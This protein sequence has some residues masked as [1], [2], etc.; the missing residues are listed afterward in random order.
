MTPG[1]SKGEFFWKQAQ[2]RAVLCLLMEET[3]PESRP[4]SGRKAGGIG[5][6]VTDFLFPLPGVQAEKV[7]V[8]MV[9]RMLGPTDG[10]AKRREPLSGSVPRFFF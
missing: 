5:I 2:K 4:M 10:L 9:M 6:T 7:L 3:V 8:Q 1:L